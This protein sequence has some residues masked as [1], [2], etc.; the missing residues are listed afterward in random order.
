MAFLCRFCC[1]CCKEWNVFL[2]HTFQSHSNEP[3]FLFTCGVEG[4]QQTF[5]TYASI[6]S[7]LN[8]KHRHA[9]LEEV[10]SEV[11]AGT[12]TY[13]S[14]EI[15]NIED[16]VSNYRDDDI[17]ESF[18]DDEDD[19]ITTGSEDNIDVSGCT[20]TENY[21]QRSAALFLLTLKERYQLTQTAINFLIRQVQNMIHYSLLNIKNSAE[22]MG[23]ITENIT[24]SVLLDYFECVDPFKSLHSEYLQTKFYKDHFGLVVSSY[25]EFTCT[26]THLS[27]HT[28]GTVS[29][30]GNNTI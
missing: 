26:C 17:T 24:Q 4:C 9:N 22:L 15:N 7:H 8:R 2:R 28:L 20:S 11:I 12:S 19:D 25:N 6:C 16:N 30:P 18:P 29:V 13:L 3:N 14:N 1:F 23:L 21:L 27:I 5:R 10:Q